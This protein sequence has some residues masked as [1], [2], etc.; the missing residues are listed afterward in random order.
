MKNKISSFFLITILLFGGGLAAIGLTSCENF[1]NG[2]DT[3]KEIEDAIAYNNAQECTVVFRA[4]AGTGEFLGSV[5]RTYKVGYESE[6]QF[7]LNTEDYVFKTLEAVCQTDRSVS[8][9]SSVEF[10]EISR[11]DKKGIYKYKVK[12]LSDTK[13]VLI[14]P[15]CLAVPK[16]TSITPAFESNGCDQ[17]SI[18]KINFNKPMKP[19]S[20]EASAISIYSDDNLSEYFEAA[21]FSSDNKTLYITPKENKLIL[22]PDGAKSVLNIEVNYDFTSLKD[23]DGLTLSEKG[24]HT[25]KINKNFGNEK[26]VKVLLQSDSVYG[27]FLSA[28]EKECILGYTIDLQFNLK[29]S[30]Y[31]FINFEAVSSGTGSES[32]SDCVAIEN[33]DY[34]D[35]TGIYKAKLRVITEQN[36]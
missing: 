15:V 17:D 29:K 1:M 22:P 34:N 25:Y 14:R 13:D 33:T 35:E 6:V 8:R 5:E 12:L 4:D 16:I 28:G 30:D 3:R 19:D 18:I 24:T 31:K 2:G 23:S 20:F 26:K 21:K 10:K 7:E 27:S 32:R 9:A 11:N 36:D